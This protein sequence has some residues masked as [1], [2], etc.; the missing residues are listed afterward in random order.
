[1]GPAGIIRESNFNALGCQTA[2]RALFD[3][4][5]IFPALSNPFL[6]VERHDGRSH[7]PPKENP[8]NGGIRARAI[9]SANFCQPSME[10]EN[11]RHAK[12]AQSE[13]D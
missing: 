6:I 11:G 2:L 4:Q 12:Y 5:R 8:R 3:Q 13:R 1:V 10:I 7:H 9:L